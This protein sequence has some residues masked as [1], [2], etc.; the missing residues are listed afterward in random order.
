MENQVQTERSIGM[1]LP[2]PVTCIQSS[3]FDHYL[4][5]RPFDSQGWGEVRPKGCSWSLG[6]KPLRATLEVCPL[7]GANIDP[8]ARRAKVY[9]TGQPH[10]VKTDLWRSILKACTYT[11]KIVFLSHDQIR[12]LSNWCRKTKMLSHSHFGPVVRPTLTGWPDEF[13][14]K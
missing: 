6:V 12:I 1:Y 14:E 3:S 13:V 9:P 11:R 8:S 4:R 7:L 5:T 10:V 2:K